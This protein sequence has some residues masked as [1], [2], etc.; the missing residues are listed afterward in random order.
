MTVSQFMNI[1]AYYG[2][3]GPISVEQDRPKILKTWFIAGL[4]MGYGPGDPNAYQRESKSPINFTINT[5][6]N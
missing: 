5:D 6:C 2:F 4:E 3:Q 1:S